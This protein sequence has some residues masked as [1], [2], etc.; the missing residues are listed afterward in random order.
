VG[1]FFYGLGPKGADLVGNEVTVILINM[2]M[3]IAV[4]SPQGA[5]SMGV[6]HSAGI[7]NSFAKKKKITYMYQ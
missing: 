4:C 3:G 7:C 6:M 1:L 5:M 2:L